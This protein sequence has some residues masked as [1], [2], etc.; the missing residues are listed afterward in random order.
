MLI[1]GGTI[2]ATA[3][4]V[5]GAGAAVYSLATSPNLVSQSC[6]IASSYY[7]V[8]NIGETSLCVVGTVASDVGS[9]IG[10]AASD[11]W[12]YISSVI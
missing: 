4:I 5:G 7:Y 10:T 8:G 6:S 1:C 9:L 11:T 2:L 12:N 3:V